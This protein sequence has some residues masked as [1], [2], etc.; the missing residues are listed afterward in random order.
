MPRPVD[1]QTAEAA[2]LDSESRL[3]RH[4]MEGNAKLRELGTTYLP[5]LTGEEEP[6]YAAR[7][8][9][10]Y[11]YNGYKSGV[12]R[13]R[14][15]VFGKPIAFA[16]DVPVAIQGDLSK[17][18]KGGIIE[19][20]DLCGHHL[21]VVAG[22]WFEAALVSRVAWVLV[23]CTKETP[24]RPPR[25][26]W[27][28]Y[29]VADYLG[30]NNGA[31]RFREC[32]LAP[33]PE[34]GWGEVTVERVRVLYD[35]YDIV[36]ETGTVRV[37]PRYE[38]E[39]KGKDDKYTVESS[40]EL[41]NVKGQPMEKVPVVRLQL[42][43]GLPFET[44]AELCRTFWQSNAAQR[45]L[46]QF[47]RQLILF[48]SGV[49]GGPPPA[50][51]PP[52]PGS[53][54]APQVLQNT[55]QMRG[56]LL[57]VSSTDPAADMKYVEHNCHAIDAGRQDLQDLL[58][59]MEKETLEPMTRRTGEVPTAKG[60]TINA[61]EAHSLLQGWALRLKDAIEQANQFAAEWLGETSGGS[62]EIPTMPGLVLSGVEEGALL[63]KAAI[64]GYISR[65]TLWVA[66]G[67][68]LGEDFDPVAEAGRL[69]AVKA[70]RQAAAEAFAKLGAE[71][72]A[73]GGG[74][75][76]ADGGPAPTAKT[77][78]ATGQRRRPLAGA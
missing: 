17:E 27:K 22:D 1:H 61:E 9:L 31:T 25:P 20:I 49:A 7:L 54:A 2:K 12:L 53:T 43:D 41:I 50:T 44:L 68:M 47:A 13:N 36:N 34:G 71:P 39:V 28:V 70:L 23:D 66:L 58:E 65:E 8:V 32:T 18:S 51:V 45:F 75:P 56:G 63:L 24:G 48:R 60:A 64:A 78:R 33:D 29:T 62:I 74:A 5:R 72:D 73:G 38:V 4:L 3:C 69:D 6:V 55:I 40:G 30:C 16:E 46:L 35:G 10:N 52:P 77:A 14:A 67:P 15:R 37:H 57:W 21:Q 42:D 11:L 26:W 59:M 19:D 76:A